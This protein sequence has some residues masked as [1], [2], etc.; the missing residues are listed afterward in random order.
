MELAFTI[1]TII[2]RRASWLSR[3]T[4]FRPVCKV[5]PTYT[6]SITSLARMRS[7]VKWWRFLSCLKAQIWLTG[8]RVTSRTA[9]PQKW[10]AD[11]ATDHRLKTIFQTLRSDREWNRSASLM[12]ATKVQTLMMCLWCKRVETKEPKGSI[13]SLTVLNNH[14]RHLRLMGPLECHP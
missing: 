6:K 11:Q 8:L 5:L 1:V 3:W 10:L 2:V 12:H 7:S 13:T 9:V 4:T 14:L